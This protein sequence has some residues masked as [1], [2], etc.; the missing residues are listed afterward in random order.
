MHFID[1]YLYKGKHRAE[2]KSLINATLGFSNKSKFNNL[3]MLVIVQ[4]RLTIAKFKH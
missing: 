3:F 1:S 2:A 4:R